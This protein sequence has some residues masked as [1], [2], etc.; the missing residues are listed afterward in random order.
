MHKENSE[1]SERR[2]HPPSPFSLLSLFI[3]LAG[4]GAGTG[5][6]AGAVPR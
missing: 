3:H 5:A 1:G 2:N 4:A 6:V